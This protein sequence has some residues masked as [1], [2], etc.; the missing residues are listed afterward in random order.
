MSI[1]QVV[2]GIAADVIVETVR[3]VRNFSVAGKL[4]PFAFG[5]P[6]KIAGSRPETTY[7]RN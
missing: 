5:H 3:I 2:A 1:G 6:V 7:T 4:P